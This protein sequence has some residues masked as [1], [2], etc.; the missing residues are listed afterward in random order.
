[1]YLCY[2]LQIFVRVKTSPDNKGSSLQIVQST[3]RGSSVTQ[4]IIC[5]VGIAYDNELILF[6]VLLGSI[7]NIIDITSFFYLHHSKVVA[8]MIFVKSISE[9]IETH[10]SL[11]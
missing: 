4:K 11:P 8:K 5:H 10:S 1:M 2:S 9:L 6:K 7:R 3:R